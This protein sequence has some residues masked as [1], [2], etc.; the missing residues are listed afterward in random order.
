MTEQYPFLGLS[1]LIFFILIFSQLDKKS[2]K[3]EVFDIDMNLPIRK[4][5]SRASR[6]NHQRDN[7]RF[8]ELYLTSGQ[9]YDIQTVDLAE[10]GLKKVNDSLVK[11]SSED[12]LNILKFWPPFSRHQTLLWSHQNVSKTFKYRIS[13]PKQINFAPF[14]YFNKEYINK[15]SLQKML[16]LGDSR[17]RQLFRIFEMV[18][19]NKSTVKSFKPEHGFDIPRSGP[20]NFKW[21]TTA[22][23]HIIESKVEKYS[24]VYISILIL[25]PLHSADFDL[26]NFLTSWNETLNGFSQLR[27]KKFIIKSAEHGNWWHNNLSDEE[28]MKRNSHSNSLIDIANDFVKEKCDAIENCFFMTVNQYL[29]LFPGTQTKVYG[30]YVHLLKRNILSTEWYF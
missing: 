2:N 8:R 10:I 28:N 11:V 27:N 4:L 21:Q 7:N 24:V 12:S 17:M 29:H 15:C 6:I 22:K 19:K 1:T 5:S 16:I 26:D 23:W 9:F 13:T 25:H 14:I 30:D 20:F 3:V 18:Y